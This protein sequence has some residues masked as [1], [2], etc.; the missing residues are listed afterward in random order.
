MPREC[1]IICDYDFN[2]IMTITLTLEH[3]SKILFI[4]LKENL[5]MK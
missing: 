2:T 1:G 4:S 5:Y 3:I